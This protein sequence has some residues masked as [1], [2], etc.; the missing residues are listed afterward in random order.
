MHQRQV[1]V[2]HELRKQI[3]RPTLRPQSLETVRYWEWDCSVKYQIISIFRQNSSQ[4]DRFRQNVCNYYTLSQ[5]AVCRNQSR[6]CPIL[7]MGLFGSALH[8][9]TEFIIIQHNPTHFEKPRGAG[10]QAGHVG[11]HADV[12]IL[13][14]TIMK[15]KENPCPTAM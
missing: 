15:G 5:A 8:N 2:N 10:F 13:R 3:T 12:F 11:I 1:A 9:P 4:F 6:Q 14:S 7:G